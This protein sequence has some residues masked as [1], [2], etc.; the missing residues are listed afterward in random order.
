MTTRRQR[1]H[2]QRAKAERRAK[3][4]GLLIKA[5][6]E[7][8]DQSLRIWQRVRRLGIAA[9]MPDPPTSTSSYRA[10]VRRLNRQRRS[11]PG[12]TLTRSD[13]SCPIGHHLSDDELP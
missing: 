12:R 2:E 11:S 4:D 13:S 8:Y 1:L 6:L 5:E 10:A 9:P 3:A 7:R